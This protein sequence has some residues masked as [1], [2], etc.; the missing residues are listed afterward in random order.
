MGRAGEPA[1]VAAVV[2]FLASRDAGYLNGVTF[3]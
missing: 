2:A 3:P 1:E